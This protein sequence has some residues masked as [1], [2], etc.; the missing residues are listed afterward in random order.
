[1]KTLRKNLRGCMLL[2]LFA[3]AEA[4]AHDGHV[5]A[6]TQGP[7]HHLA[8]AAFDI[9]LLLAATIIVGI[10]LRWLASGA[11]RPLPKPDI[12]QAAFGVAVLALIALAA[13]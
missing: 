6:P 5:H 7:L 13:A 10:A 4:V 2:M 1:M 12:R 3:A 11:T 8:G 9:V